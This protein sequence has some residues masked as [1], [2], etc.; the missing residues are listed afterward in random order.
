MHITDVRSLPQ[1]TPKPPRQRLDNLPMNVSVG[2]VR[3]DMLERRRARIEHFEYIGVDMQS[4]SDAQSHANRAVFEETLSA[5]GEEAVVR[6]VVRKCL[7]TSSRITGPTFYGSPLYNKRSRLMA[8]IRARPCGW[9]PAPVFRGRA[10]TFGVNPMKSPLDVPPVTYPMPNTIEVPLPAR[11]L[12]SLRPICSKYQVVT[13]L[14]DIEP[15]SEAV[16]IESTSILSAH[17]SR[18]EMEIASAVFADTEEEAAPTEVASVSVTSAKVEP[19]S[20]IG[21]R[22]KVSEKSPRGRGSAKGRDA[23]RSKNP[24]VKGVVSTT[25]DSDASKP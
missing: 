13:P 4:E 6:A 16:H 17:S 23:A 20:E 24:P 5:G 25:R 18:N 14:E 21:K 11:R 10:V 2:R 19:V 8:S 1:R 22:S 3:A 9:P 15:V 12:A 7:P